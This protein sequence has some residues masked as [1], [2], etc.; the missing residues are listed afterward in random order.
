MLTVTTFVEA[1][2]FGFHEGSDPIRAERK[3]QIEIVGNKNVY[4]SAYIH[5]K[6]EYIAGYDIPVLI[7]GILDTTKNDQPCI[8][9]IDDKDY[10]CI[11]IQWDTGKTVTRKDNS[12]LNYHRGFICLNTD[13]E[14]IDYARECSKTMKDIL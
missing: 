5:G 13:Q 8:L 10:E 12:P 3:G 4:L 14:G 6:A 1:A 7:D 11:L 2:P 9:R